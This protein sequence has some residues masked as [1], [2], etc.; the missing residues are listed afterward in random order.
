MT[1]KAPAGVNYRD[2]NDPLK[3]LYNAVDE[4]NDIIPLPNERNRL[5]FCINL[6][7]NK[8]ADTLMNAIEQA[9]PRSCTVSWDELE[10]KLKAKFTEKGIL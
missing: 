5:S 4:L 7:L 1:S 10:K 8:E 3:R 2:E 9:S 6:F